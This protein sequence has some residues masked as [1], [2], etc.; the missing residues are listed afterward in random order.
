M[1]DDAPDAYERLVDRLLASPHYGE[2]WAPALARPGPLRRIGR[3]PA[4]RLPARRLALSR[5]RHPGAS[6]PTSPTTASS[7]SSSPATK[8]APDDPEA[9]VATGFLRLGIYEYNQRDVRSQ[10]TNILNDMTDVTGDVFLGLGMSC[11]R[12]HDHKFDPILQKDYFRLQAF[13]APIAVARRRAAG[14]RPR[15]WPSTSGSWRRGKRRRPTSAR[16]ID[17][18]EDPIRKAARHSVRS[19][20]SR[21]TS[22]R[23]SPSRPAERTPLEEQL[24][25]LAYRQVDRRRRQSRFREE[26]Q[27]ARR[28]SMGEAAGA[29]WPSSTA[30]SL[31]PLPS[32][33]SVTDVGPIAPPT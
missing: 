17:E 14:H 19:T 22:R 16:Q 1:A 4:G 6:T 20:S 33:P 9:L 10:W 5:L 27:R 3:L 15:S 29:S 12:C 7:R 8:L 24:A 32:T 11:A 25:D 28:K 21:T 18:I 26:A 30:R 13:F 2:R 31:Q 23:S